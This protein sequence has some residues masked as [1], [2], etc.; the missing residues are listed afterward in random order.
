[1][2]NFLNFLVL[3]LYYVKLQQIVQMSFSLFF[4]LS[5]LTVNSHAITRESV[6]GL[7]AGPEPL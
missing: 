3:L 5:P 4:I 1:M 6:A 2:L 7:S